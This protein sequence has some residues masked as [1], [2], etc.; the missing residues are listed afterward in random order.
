MSCELFFREIKE[1]KELSLRFAPLGVKSQ[2]F[3]GCKRKGNY[4]PIDT[5]CHS[6]RSEDVLLR[7][8]S[9]ESRVHQVGVSEI[10]PPFGR[11]DDTLW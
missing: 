10:L 3:S 1:L 2:M 7:T 8:M 5:N 4:I 6:E 9:E 11:L